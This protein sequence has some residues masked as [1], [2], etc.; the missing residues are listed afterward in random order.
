MGTR[1][2]FVIYNP[3][4]SGASCPSSPPHHLTSNPSVASQLMW[5][6]APFLA[7]MRSPLR[8]HSPLKIKEKAPPLP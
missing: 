3:P 1:C 6:N 7:G 8:F 2:L 5:F 4:K